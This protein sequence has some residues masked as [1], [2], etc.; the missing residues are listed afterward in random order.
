VTNGAYA[1]FL[2]QVDAGVAQPPGTCAWNVDFQPAVPIGAGPNLPVLGVDWCDAYAYC[3]WAKKRLCG[4]IGG[5]PIA[6][7]NRDTLSDEWYGACAHR[8]N[9]LAF[10]YGQNFDIIKCADCNP[11]AG[12]DP[13]ASPPTAAPLP[14]GSKKGCQGGYSGLFDMS[15]NAGEWED[16]CDAG[17]VS[18]DAMVP[19]PRYDICYHRGGSFEDPRPGSPATVCLSC[20][21]RLCSTSGSTRHSRPLDVG[22]RCCLDL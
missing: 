21:S 1:Q 12:C 7:D 6:P 14:V 2:A 9:L 10:P 4:A 8:G 15:G 5:G 20:A 22:L 13:D 3:G 16:V 17:G 11:A 19:D 18:P